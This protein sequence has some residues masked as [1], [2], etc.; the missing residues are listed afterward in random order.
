M[1]DGRDA[2]VYDNVAGSEL[3]HSSFEEEGHVKNA[4][5]VAT[6]P[7]VHN[8]PHHR[9]AHRGMHNCIQCL[10]LLLIGED[11]AAELDTVELAVGEEDLR[12]KGGDDAVVGAG[13]GL[14]DLPGEDVGVDDGDAEAGELGGDGGFACGD[15]AGEADDYEDSVSVYMASE[16][17][18]ER[19][20]KHC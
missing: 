6:Q 16:A 14:D 7:A 8:L 5:T 10:A 9:G 18:K 11:D 12:A 20:T 15:P 19:R 4:Y 17:T 2:P 1:L 13:A 3:E